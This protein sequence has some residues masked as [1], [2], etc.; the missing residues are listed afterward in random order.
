[1]WCILGIVKS[2]SYYTRTT[3]F[4]IT[5]GDNFPQFI[6]PQSPTQ[7]ASFPS[8]FRSATVVQQPKYL[9]VRDG[10]PIPWNRVP[11]LAVKP[12]LLPDYEQQIPNMQKLN[13]GQRRAVDFVLSSGLADGHPKR[14]SWNSSSSLSPDDDEQADDDYDYVPEDEDQ[15]YPISE[16]ELA[17]ILE[18]NDRVFGGYTRKQKLEKLSCGTF[19]CVVQPS[20]IMRPL[21]AGVG[22]DSYQGFENHF[23]ISSGV[24]TDSPGFLSET[25]PAV[26]A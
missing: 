14:L 1:M 22:E 26:V 20:S 23:I 19:L 9:K 15:P 10:E 6:F 5:T 2:L 8:L 25:T 12:N 16:E 3:H 17:K 24:A 7:V 18:E 11:L 21:R 4:P 13:D